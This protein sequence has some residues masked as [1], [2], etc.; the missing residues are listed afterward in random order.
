MLLDAEPGSAPIIL[1]VTV[2]DIKVSPQ[3][4]LASRPERPPVWDGLPC[5][6]VRTPSDELLS[7]LR[8]RR[9]GGQE[10]CCV[11]QPAGCRTAAG[12]GGAAAAHAALH[13]ADADPR[14][15]APL[16]ASGQRRHLA[17]QHTR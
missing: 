11:R 1:Y 14:P 10:V 3:C 7:D 2:D 5:G 12:R 4:P 16:H 17:P 6:R 15:H 13:P 9:P 8:E